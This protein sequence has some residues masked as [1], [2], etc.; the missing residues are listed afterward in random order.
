MFIALLAADL[1]LDH[2]LSFADALIYGTG[3]HHDALL[4][5]SDD[6][7]KQLPGVAYYPKRLQE[8]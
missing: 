4:V 5:T 7:F 3:R 2:R 6:H 8:R 1:A